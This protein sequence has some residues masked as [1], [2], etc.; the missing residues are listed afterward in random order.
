[1]SAASQQADCSRA[2]EG[3]SQH[4]AATTSDGRATSRREARQAGPTA[5][6]GQGRSAPGGTGERAVIGAADIAGAGGFIGATRLIGRCCLCV[7]QKPSRMWRHLLPSTNVVRP[8]VAAALDAIVSGGQRSQ[9][10]L[11]KGATRAFSTS[12]PRPAKPT[13]AA[14]ATA[15]ASSPSVAHPARIAFHS[16]LRSL[17]QQRRFSEFLLLHDATMR[18]ASGAPRDSSAPSPNCSAEVQETLAQLSVHPLPPSLRADATTY[19]LAV[20]VHAAMHDWPACMSLFWHLHSV[21]YRDPH[22]QPLTAKF[23]AAMIEAAA[24]CRGASV[25]QVEQIMLMA[26]KPANSNKTQPKANHAPVVAA[27]PLLRSML[28]FYLSVGDADTALD[29]F[30][31]WSAGWSHPPDGFAPHVSLGQGVR[32][33]LFQALRSCQTA[34]PD[35]AAYALLLHA[36][37][38][39]GNT[40]VAHALMT[41][42]R[43]SDASVQSK[44]RGVVLLRSE[45]YMHAINAWNQRAIME[46]HSA[47]LIRQANAQGHNDAPG[48]TTQIDKRTPMEQ[49]ESGQASSFDQTSV[50]S[51]G[52]IDLSLP[53]TAPEYSYLHASCL[54]R[55]LRDRGLP[56]DEGVYNAMILSA[57]LIGRADEVEQ[58]MDD[59]K[60]Q[61]TDSQTREGPKHEPAQDN[62][63]DNGDQT[64]GSLAPTALTHAHAYIACVL[65]SSNRSLSRAAEHLSRMDSSLPLL[66]ADAS[67]TKPVAVARFDQLQSLYIHI[68]SLL[69]LK[70]Q[71]SIA[72]QII[73]K[74]EA[75]S[76]ALQKR[77]AAAA[78]TEA[79]E[80]PSTASAASIPAAGPSSSSPSSSASPRSSN[81]LVSLALYQLAMDSCDVSYQSSQCVQLFRSLFRRG[82]RPDASI[83]MTLLRGLVRCRDWSGAMEVIDFLEDQ[84]SNV[85]L[86]LDSWQ[87]VQP[88]MQRRMFQTTAETAAT[89]REASAAASDMGHSAD[90]MHELSSAQELLRAWR[91]PATTQAAACSSSH[92]SSSNGTASVSSHAF[93]SPQKQRAFVSADSNPGTRQPLP[94]LS[95]FLKAAYADSS[96]LLAPLLQTVLPPPGVS[97]LQALRELVQERIDERA[98]NK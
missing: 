79:T 69:T 91:A 49:S 41:I 74:L 3:D 7:W 85:T 33:R 31:A 45:M 32:A 12:D 71:W 52:L 42:M 51:L 46:F 48:D 23:Y 20:E 92:S 59:M 96:S 34:Q 15:T 60:A 19:Q 21:G 93:Y 35:Q 58:L 39:T 26:I 61:D 14:A 95:P 73:A 98:Q 44:R 64:R 1:M 8:R 86:G 22:E 84:Q 10:A 65:E 88:L 29:F 28:H 43:H 5:R 9:R 97:V 53:C 57:A 55:E 77:F 18:R 70:Q 11:E 36:C 90:L 6:A 66:S 81:F 78:D 76:D 80:G 47:P 63:Q 25:E 2:G 4:T 54:W 87:R 83:Y 50:S 37:A 38:K 82:V 75:L 27:T 67:L 89:T 40:S 62:A 30:H 24:T 17:V 56:R 68:L 94:A 72:L 13:S 16:L